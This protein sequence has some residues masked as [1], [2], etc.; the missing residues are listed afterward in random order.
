MTAQ[1]SD[2]D[3]QVVRALHQA[4][5]D[6]DRDAFLRLLADDVVWNVEGASPLAGAYQGRDTAW[7]RYFEPLWPAPARFVDHD[8]VAHG[9]HVVAFG[10]QVHNFGEGERSYPSVEVVRLRNG[11]VAERWGFTTGQDEL[12]VFLARGCAA[13]A[14]TADLPS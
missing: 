6:R 1:D 14:E 2:S 7:E 10:A 12:D 8:V 9:D 13:D 3:P 5:N 11:K 4:Y